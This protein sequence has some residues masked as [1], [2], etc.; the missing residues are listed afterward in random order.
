MHTYLS[1]RQCVT[2]KFGLG[3]VCH[4]GNRSGNAGI[5]VYYCYTCHLINMKF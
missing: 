2:A 4:E 5:N 3:L 1:Q